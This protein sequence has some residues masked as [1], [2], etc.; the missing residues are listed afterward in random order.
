LRWRRGRH[1]LGIF[2]NIYELVLRF[3]VKKKKKKKKRRGRRKRK[4]QFK[5]LA[6]PH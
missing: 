5:E 2:Y 1:V 3:F 4:I 6:V